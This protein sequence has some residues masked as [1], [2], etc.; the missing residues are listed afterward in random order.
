MNYPTNRPLPP[1]TDEEI[2]YEGKPDPVTREIPWIDPHQ[3]TQSLTWEQHEKLDI[4]GARALVMIAASYFQ[5]P[6]CPIP[7]D[8]W[9]LLWDDALRT[10]NIVSRNQFFD[11]H[12]AVGL[13]MGT[14][15]TDADELLEALPRYCS[16]DE[17]VA[18]GETGIDPIQRGGETARWPLAD[19]RDVVRRQM[20]IAADHDLPVIVHTPANVV[21]EEGGSV[22]SQM[23]GGMEHKFG[24]G[25]PYSEPLF[26]MADAKRR[27]VEHDVEL[28]QEA[29]LPEERLVLDHADGSIVDYVMEETDCYLSFS[30]AHD[31]VGPGE[32]AGVIEEHGPER[33]M[34]DSDLANSIQTEGDVFLIR[35]LILDLLRLGISPDD[36]RQVVHDNPADMLGLS[37]GER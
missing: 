35:R 3:H 6:Y 25:I 24:R 5:V 18:V 21:D 4:A 17:V 26:E 28:A 10:A 15:I 29:G 13:H 31:V 20:R 32:I 22:S 11:V 9:R 14:R 19:Q 34:V 30:L 37:Y 12:L 7:A 23:S 33:V 36:V 1:V 16:L 2:G 27:A 8:H